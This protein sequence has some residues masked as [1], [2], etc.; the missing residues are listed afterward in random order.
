[1]QRSIADGL[2]EL[3]VGALLAMLGVLFGFGMGGV[4]GLFEDRLKAGLA[5]DAEK[6]LATVYAGDRDRAKSVTEKA[7]TYFKRAHLHGGAIGAAAIG[8]ILVM[9]LAGVAPL[10][11]KLAALALGAGSLGY[12]VFWLL[13]GMRAPGLGS[14]SA[15]KES[16]SWLAV[17]SSA[18]LLGGLVLAIAVS[19]RALFATAKS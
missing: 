15:A 17:P 6:V 13:A 19:A 16:L 18:A 10:P 1:M 4:F 8:G 9:S 12:P 5:A 7:W 2:R 14:T 11:G 3:R